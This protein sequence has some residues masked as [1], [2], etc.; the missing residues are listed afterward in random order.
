MAGLLLTN[1]LT[2][3][4]AGF[5]QCENNTQGKCFNK[6]FPAVKRPTEKQISFIYRIINIT[7]LHRTL[8]SALAE[9]FEDYSVI[10]TPALG[11]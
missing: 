4:K 3:I 5:I 9:L 6:S 2:G 7:A 1:S 11:A 10:A 8:I